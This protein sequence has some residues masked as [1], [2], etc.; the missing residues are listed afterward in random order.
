[1][2]AARRESERPG[3]VEEM[4]RLAEANGFTAHRGLVLDFG[5]GRGQD[6][7]RALLLSLLG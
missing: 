5:V 4:R 2:C 6:A 3:F 7:V 1:M